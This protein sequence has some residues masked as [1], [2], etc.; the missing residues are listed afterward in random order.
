MKFNQCRIEKRMKKL[1]RLR[2]SGVKIPHIIDA[3]KSF[4]Q[5]RLYYRLMNL[6]VSI[7]ELPVSRGLF[8]TPP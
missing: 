5:P 8:Y 4:V 2:Y 7:T 3:I 6:V 1:E